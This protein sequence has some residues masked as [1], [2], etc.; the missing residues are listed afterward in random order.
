MKRSLSSLEFLLAIVVSLLLVCCVG[1]IVLS[2]ISLKTE[3]G[4]EPAVLSGQMVIT[5]G[6]VFSDELKNSSS[7]KFKSLAFDIQ[8]LVRPQAFILKGTGL[9]KG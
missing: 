3:G 9:L 2:W 1:L 8:Q 4:V 5:D 7:L 6:A